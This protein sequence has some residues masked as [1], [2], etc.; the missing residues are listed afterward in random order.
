MNC[1]S[2]SLARR[3]VSCII[4]LINS[5]VLAK[6]AGFAGW[7]TETAGLGRVS[8]ARSMSRDHFASRFAFAHAAPE[9]FEP[10]RPGM[11]SCSMRQ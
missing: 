3:S 4:N 6:S 8:H 2:N 10:G 7:R 1:H 5:R 9:R 11:K